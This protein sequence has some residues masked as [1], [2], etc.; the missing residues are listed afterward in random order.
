MCGQNFDRIFHFFCRWLGFLSLWMEILKTS[1]WK[2]M[3]GLIQSVR[4]ESNDSD[5]WS[6][7]GRHSLEKS[8]SF[9][10]FLLLSSFFSLFGGFSQVPSKVNVLRLASYSLFVCSVWLK[11]WE[12]VRAYICITLVDSFPIKKKD[13]LIDWH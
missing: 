13:W 10:N 4:Y 8:G 9:T 6:V 5:I 11:A 1:L 12:Y 2:L 7:R 3:L